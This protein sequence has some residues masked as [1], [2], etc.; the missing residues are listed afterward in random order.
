[1][2]TQCPYCGQHCEVDDS[3]VGKNAECP[4]CKHH[5]PIIQLKK[6]N[7]QMP[8][9]DSSLKIKTECPYCSQRYEIDKALEGKLIECTKCKNTFS[10]IPL[11]SSDFLQPIGEST[12][13]KDARPELSLSSI[14][15]WFCFFIGIGIIFLALIFYS[16]SLVTENSIWVLL[17]VIVIVVGLPF[18]LIPFC[19]ISIPSFHASAHR[20]HAGR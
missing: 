15:R 17:A 2:K 3:H 14:L 1:M 13:G 20:N 11:I 19:R 5:F 7:V 12:K 10:I 4:Q 18:L 8:N 9:S 6:V 16:L